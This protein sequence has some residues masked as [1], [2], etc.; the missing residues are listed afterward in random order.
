M[1]AESARSVGDRRVLCF[2]RVFCSG[3]AVSVFGVRRGQ[4]LCEECPH[5]AFLRRFGVFS[6]AVFEGTRLELARRFWDSVGTMAV[7]GV[8]G[9]FDGDCGLVGG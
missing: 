5:F 2:S 4:S 1:A 6:D 9:D 7:V 8:A 3:L